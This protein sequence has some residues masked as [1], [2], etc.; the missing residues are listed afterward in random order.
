M[1][2]MLKK[3]TRKLNLPLVT[4][5]MLMLFCLLQLTMTK[6]DPNGRGNSKPIHMENLSRANQRKE[7]LMEERN[8]QKNQFLGEL[9]EKHEKK[10]ENISNTD[11]EQQKPF[12]LKK[13]PSLKKRKPLT[14]EEML[15]LVKHHITNNPNYLKDGNELKDVKYFSPEEV[16]KFKIKSGE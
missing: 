5:L 2:K 4:K 3:A 14:Q 15:K 1:F 9:N 16:E 7:P 8:I 6:A 11:K 12:T 10:P 13:K